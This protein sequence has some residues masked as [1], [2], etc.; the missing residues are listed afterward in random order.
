MSCRTNRTTT[1]L[2]YVDIVG[3]CMTVRLAK[4]KSVILTLDADKIKIQGNR[5][6]VGSATCPYEI[7]QDIE[8]EE[9]K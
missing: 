9:D 4:T 1:P 8:Q 7:I 6:A 3:Y 2:I 5:V